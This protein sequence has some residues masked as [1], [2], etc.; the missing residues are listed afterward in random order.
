MRGAMAKAALPAPLETPL[1]KLGEVLLKPEMWQWTSS[2][3]YRMVYAKL[4][5][6][7]EEASITDETTL[8]EV[9][10]GSTGAALAYAG[11]V[12]GLPVEIHAYAS[13]APQKRA[14][15]EDSGARLI[16]HPTETP[17]TSLLEE[18]RRKVDAGGYW[19]LGQYDRPSTVA[20]YDELC[21]EFIGQLRAATL[22]PQVLVC[23]VGTGGLIQSLGRAL[24]KAYSGIR[25]VA[26]E[27]AAGSA[28][29]GTRNTSSF[30]LGVEDP[31]DRSFPD[32]VVRVARPE[33]LSR[34][35]EI[36]LGESA[37]AAYALAADRSWGTTVVVAP[38]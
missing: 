27:P 21:K 17:F 9:T 2:V 19:H 11:K 13:I 34:I 16:L 5:K 35:D 12:L 20:A 29:E 6:A 31:Y 10:S 36:P 33:T 18:V 28:I 1:L 37:S 24:R 25:V 3:K 30:H 4:Q 7:F 38:D 23:P 8:V 32:E 26:L 14:K 22:S 15:I